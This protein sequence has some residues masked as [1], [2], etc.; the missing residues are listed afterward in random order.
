M[1]RWLYILTFFIG[2]V[3]GIG[4][5]YLATHILGPYLPEMLQRKGELVEGRVVAKEE[6]APVLLLT[7]DTSQGALL[8]TFT[9]KVDEIALLVQEGDGVEL[10]L[11][12][13]EPF[14]EDPRIKRVLKG[15]RPVVP[16]APPEATLPAPPQQEKVEEKP[17]TITEEVKPLP[18]PSVSPPVEE[19]SGNEES[20]ASEDGKKEAPAPTLPPVEGDPTP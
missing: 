4:G 12:R 15:A 5:T 2:L 8:A 17:A 9:K 13:Y 1:M 7:I 11:R 6:K 10:F 18:P 14:V 19:Q 16:P 3:L 20:A